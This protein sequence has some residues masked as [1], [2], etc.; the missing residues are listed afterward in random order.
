[1]TLATKNGAIIVKNGLLAEN[2]G[3]C[4]GWYC[5]LDSTSDP[6]VPCC[7]SQ[8]LSLQISLVAS[9]QLGS[10]RFGESA[11][12]EFVARF[13][14][15]INKTVTLQKAGDKYSFLSGHNYFGTGE[16]RFGA[17]V[18]ID[19]GNV[20][21]CT[22][23]VQEL[24]FN[25]KWDML[26][27]DFSAGDLGREPAGFQ[28]GDLVFQTSGQKNRL[29]TMASTF[30]VGQDPCFQ[31]KTFSTEG[32]AIPGFGSATGTVTLSLA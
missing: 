17:V 14:V 20:C 29:L 28:Y 18:T 1:M 16:S 9:P 3:C 8:S 6:E 10:P 2:C 21:L 31:P 19:K 7:S 32:Q 23:S 4:G 25:W 26:A 22:I 11:V 27:S 13:P 30:N 5:Q 12:S 15:S 24:Y